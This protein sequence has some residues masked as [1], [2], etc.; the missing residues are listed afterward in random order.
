MKVNKVADMKMDMVVDLVVGKVA[1]M[2]VDKVIRSGV[3]WVRGRGSGVR[4]SEG[5]SLVRGERKETRKKQASSKWCHWGERGT[6]RRMVRRP[7]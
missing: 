4:H 7:C 2:K 1:N 6:L 3:G 5:E